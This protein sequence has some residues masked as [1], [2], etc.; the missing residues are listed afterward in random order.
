MDVAGK[1][2]GGSWNP[3]AVAWA[4]GRMRLYILFFR[5]AL[6]NTEPLLTPLA[7]GR[8]KGDC[9]IPLCNPW[10]SPTVRACGSPRRQRVTT[11]RHQR[12]PDTMMADS[13]SCLVACS[14][15]PPRPDRGE[16]DPVS[17]IVDI[18]LV[19]DCLPY[20]WDIRLD[21]IIMSRTT[22]IS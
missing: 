8:A 17:N 15:P 2:R 3:G 20:N 19:G 16:T 11:A 7:R 4:R 12:V 22:H 21:I 6:A 1:Q 18:P 13:A 5:C 9:A 14:P 10:H